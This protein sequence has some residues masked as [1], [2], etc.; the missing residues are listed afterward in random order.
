MTENKISDKYRILKDAV[1]DVWD[2][3]SFWTKAS[4]VE[5]EMDGTTTNLQDAYKLFGHAIVRRSKAYNI[6]DVVYSNNSKSW[7]MFICSR[8]GTTHTSEPSSYTVADPGLN[9]YD[10][11]AMFTTYSVKPIQSFTNDGQDPYYIPAS[12]LVYALD[13]ELTANVDGVAKKFYLDYHNNRYGFNIQE[14]RDPNSFIA[15]G[16][17]RYR[18]LLLNKNS[19]ADTPDLIDVVLDEYTGSY[20]NRT[21]SVFRVEPINIDHLF[22]IDYQLK[23]EQYVWVFSF[24]KRGYYSV[25]GGAMTLYE[26]NSSLQVLVDYNN[27]PVITWAIGDED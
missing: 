21:Y 20:Y 15:F 25:N 24:I 26:A 5:L 3:I 19:S 12:N 17:G 4:D 14:N 11:S 2:R 27:V 10:G 9:F 18:A 6:G 23:S 7:A 13:S 16:G 22:T 8:M 1:N